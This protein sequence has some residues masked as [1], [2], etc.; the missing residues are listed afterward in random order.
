MLY[1]FAVFVCIEVLLMGLGLFGV[2]CAIIGIFLKITLKQVFSDQFLFPAYHII[3]N[4]YMLI[5]FVLFCFVFL[6]IYFFLEL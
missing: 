4:F 2:N 1:H 3:V 5:R 6:V